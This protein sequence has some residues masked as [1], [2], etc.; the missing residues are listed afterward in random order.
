MRRLDE[1]LLH[2]S[3]G[4]L[5]MPLGW[6]LWVGV[7]IAVN[8]VPPLFVL[9]RVEAR[10][11]LVAITVAGLLMSLLTA[12]RGFGRLLGLGHAP[13]LLL[14]PWIVSRWPEWPA[15]EPFG[16]WLRLLVAV[17]ATSLVFD[18]ADVARYL[19]GERRPTIEFDP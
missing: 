2:F 8:V 5:A 6:R 15:D 16:L 3:L 1:G 9:D 14:L 11:T 13:W 7:L 19:A 12:W 4:V 10:W 17:N 18:V